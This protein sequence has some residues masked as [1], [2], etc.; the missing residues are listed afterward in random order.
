MDE[1]RKLGKKRIEAYLRSVEA[2][3]KIAPPGIRLEIEAR[4]T[5]AFVFQSKEVKWS[6]QQDIQ[7]EVCS[8]SS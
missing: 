7:G 1:G 5:V 4:G 2:S 8:V 6:V 3:R